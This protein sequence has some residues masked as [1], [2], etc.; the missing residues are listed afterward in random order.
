MITKDKVLAIRD[1]ADRLLKK[2]ASE[3]K[4]KYRKLSMAFADTKADIERI[5]SVVQNDTTVNQM[6]TVLTGLQTEI[7]KQLKSVRFDTEPVVRAVEQL[8]LTINNKET[9]NKDIVDGLARVERA[10]CNIK[11]TKIS[12]RTD[13]L[14]EAL[15]N[16][17][18]GEIDFPESIAINNFP[19]QKVPQPVTNININP[20]RGFIKTTSATVSST[21]TV[22]PTYGVLDNRRAVMVYNNSDTVTVYIGGSDVTSSNGMPVPPKSYSPIID[23]GVRMI[24]YGVTSSSTANVRCMEISNDAIGG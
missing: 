14:I 4:D 11:Q 23:A 22:L 12:D 20:L 2:M 1:N 7:A 9:N 13:E 15:K 18:M 24:L 21:L 6:S 5:L 16:V 17:K 3:E 19:P 10:V 8:K